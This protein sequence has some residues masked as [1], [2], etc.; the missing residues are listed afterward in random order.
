MAHNLLMQ[1]VCFSTADG[2]PPE[3]V[4]LSFTLYHFD[5]RTTPRALLLSPEDAQA[6]SKRAQ[7]QE[8]PSSSAA[9]GGGRGRRMGGGGG[10]PRADA[11]VVEVK[12]LNLDGHVIVSTTACRRG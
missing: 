6:A 10:M 3:S 11:I 4:Y 9:A 7:A 2:T 5:A 8:E 12:E 1:F